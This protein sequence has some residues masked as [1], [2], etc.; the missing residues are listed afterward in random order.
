MGSLLAVVKRLVQW[1]LGAIGFRVYRRPRLKR[2]VDIP[3]ADFYRPVVQPG[4]L[5]SPWLGY[6][7]FGR[8][9]AAAAPYTLVSP[10]RGHQL[11]T[12]LMHALAL[13]GDVWECGVYRGGTA[14]L[15]AEILGDRDPTHRKQLHLFD[16]FAGMPETDAA[17][18][19]HRAGDFEDTSVGAVQRAV[20]H[21]EFVVLH[22]GVIPATFRGLE[23]ARIAFAHVDVDLYD[24]VLACC[25][26]IYPRLAASGV[27][28]FDDYGFPACPG[29][30]AAVDAFCRRLDLTPTVLPTGQALLIKR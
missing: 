6:G 25:D 11:Y 13:P 20:G 16:T 28:V 18:D 3:D 29:A 30:R 24:A 15:L 17:R 14:R 27:L 1:G 4:L 5:F 26:F 21:A 2:G 12:L 10:D 23:D 9:T 7:A 22:P 8:Y 19:V